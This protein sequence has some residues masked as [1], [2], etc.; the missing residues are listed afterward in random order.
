MESSKKHIVIFS[1]GFGVRYDDLGLLSGPDGVAEALQ[2]E[3]IETVLFDYF[4]I[5]EEKKTLTVRT[6]SETASKFHEV[7]EKTKQQY[8]DA[9][10]D[11]V[12]HSQGTVSVAMAQ[13]TGIR[14]VIFLAPVFDLSLERTLK[15]YSTKP[16][17]HIDLDGVSTLYAMGGYVRYVPKEY[18]AE[19]ALV[20][21]I[22]LYNKLAEATEL[23]A[24]E[25]NQDG[26]LEKVDLSDLN[27]KIIVLGLDGDHSFNGDARGPLIE[28]IKETCRKN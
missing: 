12:A 18:W 1:H 15:R 19:R 16:D 23:V 22:P 25:A 20:Q 28:K 2:A 17:T 8:P 5:D 21:P 13:P 10:I 27:P 24:I 3:G 6:L 11:V 9:I 4:I 14:K 26:I 7:L